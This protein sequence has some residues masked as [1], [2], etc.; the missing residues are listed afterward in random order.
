MRESVTVWV[1]VGVWLC[2][3]AVHVRRVWLHILAMPLICP[4]LKLAASGLPAHPPNLGVSVVNLP[5]ASASCQQLSS[6][7]GRAFSSH[8]F[9]CP[10]LTPPVWDPT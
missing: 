9:R 4:R 3:C 5:S 7:L 1:G 10:L 8:M 2:M 6:C